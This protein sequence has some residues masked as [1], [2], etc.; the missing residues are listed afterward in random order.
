MRL[1]LALSVAAAPCFA[2]TDLDVHPQSA[3]F[4]TYLGGHGCTLSPDSVDGAVAQGILRDDI[5]EITGAALENGEAREQGDYI[6]FAD[7]SCEIRLPE[8][9]SKYSVTDA[10]IREGSPYVREVFEDGDLTI[11]EEGCFVDDAFTMFAELEEFDPRAGF[12]AFMAFTGAGIISGDVRFYA[13]SPLSTPKGFQITTGPDCDSAPNVAQINASH[14]FL[15]EGFGEYVRFVGRATECGDA[16][17]HEAGP[18]AADLQGFNPSLDID[19][20]PPINAW[21][22]FEFLFITMAA[23][24]HEGMSDVDRGTPRPPLCHYSN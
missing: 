22:D 21:L 11:V 15:N 7:T 3:R 2:Q 16:I 23:G 6:V 12:A 13:T 24:W 8:I 20:Q 14:R 5:L 18:F 4:L 19:D 9:A 1:A 10:V 17:S